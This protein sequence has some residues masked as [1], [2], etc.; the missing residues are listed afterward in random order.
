MQLAFVP[1]AASPIRRQY[2]TLKRQHPD[3]I[4]FFQLGDFYETFEED[5]RLLAEVCD[6]AL[7]SR[8]M[9]KGERIPMAGVPIH[10]AEAYLARLVERGHHIAICQQMEDPAAA[11]RAGSS[12]VRR[13]VTRVITPG[14]LVDPT[15]LSAE[16]ANYLAAIVIEPKAAGLAY[17]DISTGEFAC[18]QF[19]DSGHEDAL[20]AELWRIRPAECLVDSEPTR[21]SIV[22]DG[23]YTTSND[24]L[25][26]SVEVERALC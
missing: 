13:E 14:T 21:S 8:E 17:A 18:V 1:P 25:F 19:S 9:G 10:A 2:L 23:W 6:I 15:L 20:R 16:R 5:A 11:S 7:T 4:L 12:V 26:R 24:S 22:P 3:A